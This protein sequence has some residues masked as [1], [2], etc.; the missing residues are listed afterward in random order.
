M[1]HDS[2]GNE[3][4]KGDRVY[5]YARPVLSYLTSPTQ[6]SVD[7]HCTDDGQFSKLGPKTRHEG[8]VKEVYPGSQSCNVS[9]VMDDDPHAGQVTCN[10]KFFTRVPA[11][12]AAESAG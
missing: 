8:E 2:Q 10:S 11:T 6:A 9:V 4:K 5:C 12:E 7:A 3:L 1:P